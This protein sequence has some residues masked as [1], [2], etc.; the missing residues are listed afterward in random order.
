MFFSFSLQKKEKIILKKIEGR[1]VQKNFKKDDEK[2]FFCRILQDSSKLLVKS[3]LRLSYC[4]V[5]FEHQEGAMLGKD[6]KRKLLA[7][8]SDLV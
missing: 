8:E 7:I 3:C 1:R 2:K 6:F 4:Q 5:D